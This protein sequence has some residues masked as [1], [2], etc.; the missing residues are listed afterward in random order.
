MKFFIVAILGLVIATVANADTSSLN[1]NLPSS[2]Q[3]YASD[4]IR[5]DGVECQNAIG[6]STNLEFG[7]V[8]IINEGYNDPFN[9][10]FSSDPLSTP[11]LGQEKDVSVY[12]RITIPIGA[13][14]E[15]INCNALYK[16]ELEIKRMEVQKLKAE[17]NNLRN[18]RFVGDKT[19]STVQ[20][21]VAQ[22]VV[23]Q[24]DKGT[25]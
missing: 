9:N 19:P 15:R 25:N 24:G 2:P 10:S 4:R 18:L 6:S 8:G 20:T 1:L 3:S 21:P 14:K 13:P 5:A 17:L 23:A 11:S 16:L 12:A 22:S 7:V